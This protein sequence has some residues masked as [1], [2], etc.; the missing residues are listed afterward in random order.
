MTSEEFTDCQRQGRGGPVGFRVADQQRGEAVV[1]HQAAVKARV[2][3]RLRDGVD[4]PPLDP[5]V[6]VRLAGNAGVI[7]RHAV[8]GR[9]DGIGRA[10]DRRV[11]AENG[12]GEQRREH[13]R[14]RT[15][16]GKQ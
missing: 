5:V 3:D 1:E 12:H 7:V 6:A 9:L 11:A 16:H 4:A 10:V 14:P 13:E 2:A 15:A 8:A